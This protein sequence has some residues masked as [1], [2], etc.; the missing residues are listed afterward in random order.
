[1]NGIEFINKY[2]E[3][4]NYENIYYKKFNYKNIELM[5]KKKYVKYENII[6]NIFSDVFLV[7]ILLKYSNRYIYSLDID[8]IHIDKIYNEFNDIE[9]F[10]DRFCECFMKLKD[11]FRFNQ[12]VNNYLDKYY[13]IIIKT[14]IYFIYNK[15]FE[16][17]VGKND[18]I[19]I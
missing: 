8:L 6:I 9:K 15:K 12:E 4:I 10:K 14:I 19:I 5:L 2:L 1:M 16:N 3:C 7:S 17:L 13:F 11:E 18:L